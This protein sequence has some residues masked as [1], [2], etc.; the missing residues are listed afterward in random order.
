MGDRLGARDVDHIRRAPDL[1]PASD[2]DVPNGL[3]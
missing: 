1:M 2:L 3:V